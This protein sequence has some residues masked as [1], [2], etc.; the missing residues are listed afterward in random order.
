MLLGF[1]AI[2]RKHADCNGDGTVSYNDTLAVTTNYAMVHAKGINHSSASKTA[3][4]PDLF[5][6][7]SG[8]TPK[9]GTTVSI[10]IKLGTA[11]TPISKIAGIAAHIMIDGTAPADTPSLAYAGSWLGTT[12]NSIHFNKAISKAHLDWA[13]ARTDQHNKGGSGTLATLTFTI[14]PGTEGQQMRLYFDNVTLVD[15]NGD[16]ITQVNVLDD[17]LTILNANGV[18]NN[19]KQAPGLIVLPNPSSGA[20][21]IRF[22]VSA[23]AL[24]RIELRDMSGRLVLHSSGDA[25][26][27]LQTISLPTERLS[28]GVYVVY[29][30]MGDQMIAPVRWIKN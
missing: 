1:P 2:N 22:Y 6:D 17:T 11:T 30:N 25:R 20:C 27:G 29:V 18:A 21:N 23:A 24:Y 4:L 28:S 10:P 14:P 3:G 15:S 13:Y 5:F 8:I 19:P 9:A 16:K 12:T 26:A 7:L